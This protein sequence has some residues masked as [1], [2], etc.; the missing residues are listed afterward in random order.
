ML[1]EDAPLVATF[2][3]DIRSDTVPVIHTV[4]DIVDW[5]LRTRLPRGS[6]F[7]LEEGG[8]VIGWLDAFEGEVVQLFVRRAD[9]GRGH[10]LTLLNYAKELFPDGLMLYAFEVNVGARRFYQREG[11]TEVEWG[12][13][14]GNEERQPDVKLVWKPG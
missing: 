9:I 13:G 12:D 1:P 5:I 3:A 8:E 11:F 14:S 10:G 6:S 7:V 4:D 2:Y